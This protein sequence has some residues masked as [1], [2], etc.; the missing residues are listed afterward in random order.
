[1]TDE[2]LVDILIADALKSCI[3]KYGVEGIEDKI[4]EIYSEVPYMRDKLLTI[5]QRIYK[6]K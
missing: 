2:E 1:M 3:N 6:R 5:Y 4:K